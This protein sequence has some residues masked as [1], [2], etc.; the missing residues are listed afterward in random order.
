MRSI[1]S[2]DVD[3][4]HFIEGSARDQQDNQDTGQSSQFNEIPTDDTP[5]SAENDALI[6]LES[7]D[8]GIA[9]FREQ[10]FK[11]NP[12]EMSPEANLFNSTEINDAYAPDYM[13]R[14][15]RQSEILSSWGLPKPPAAPAGQG[16]DHADD[17]S[18]DVDSS[19]ADSEVPGILTPEGSTI[20]DDE[21]D[22]ADRFDSLPSFD[23][24]SSDGQ[25]PFPP[26]PFSHLVPPSGHFTFNS[27]SPLLT[28]I[29]QWPGGAYEEPM[30]RPEST[31]LY[32]DTNEDSDDSDSDIDERFP[33]YEPIF[34]S[35]PQ[36][37][38]VP[39]SKESSVCTSTVSF[40]SHPAETQSDD[41]SSTVPTVSLP[42][43]GPEVPDSQMIDKAP[44]RSL[45]NLDDGESEADDPTEKNGFSD[46]C[47]IYPKE[48]PARLLTASLS[49]L[50]TESE[51]MNSMTSDMIP[52]IEDELAELEAMER[53]RLG[54]DIIEVMEVPWAT[55]MQSSHESISIHSSRSS[56][57]TES[58]H[59]L[60]ASVQQRL[61]YLKR[62]QNLVDRLRV[63][64]SSS[65]DSFHGSEALYASE[66]H[67]AVENWLQGSEDSVQMTRARSSKNKSRT[68]SSS[69]ENWLEQSLDAFQSSSGASHRSKP[70]RLSSSAETIVPG[71]YKVKQT[72][73]IEGH[74]SEAIE[75]SLDEDGS[76]GNKTEESTTLQ[77][78]S[79]QQSE[80]RDSPS[81]LLNKGKKAE[82][83]E[84]VAQ[85]ALLDRIAQI[86][87]ENRPAESAEAEQSENTILNRPSIEIDG[88]EWSRRAARIFAILQLLVD[89]PAPNFAVIATVIV[90]ELSRMTDLELYDALRAIYSVR[91]ASAEPETAE[92]DPASA[93]Y[94]NLVDSAILH[95]QTRRA[96][97]IVDDAINADAVS[98]E[99]SSE[100]IENASVS[101][102][103]PVLDDEVEVDF[104][105]TEVETS[106]STK[107][108]SETELFFRQN[109]TFRRIFT[110]T[111]PSSMLLVLCWISLFDVA[112][113]AWAVV[114]GRIADA[115]H[116][117]S[118]MSA[119][120][121]IEA[122]VLNGI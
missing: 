110:R 19:C 122:A 80:P 112:L 24:Q 78:E 2:V 64:F 101:N 60:V 68:L 111:G 17:S 65:S 31:Y 119:V 7:D 39:S 28:G 120:L 54:S 102:G 6:C 61:Q 77:S 42:P 87:Q 113:F 32:R 34:S 36:R 49:G 73:A 66:S 40:P 98:D 20:C 96:H 55:S 109:F 58:S 10:S 23:S 70:R 93:L 76:S 52:S 92:P 63:R 53:S 11:I 95:L 88:D 8:E 69:A 26:S 47:S 46:T 89:R 90:R 116:Y 97:N 50:P 118:I 114:A 94:S 79:D 99:S 104:T 13:A 71:H 48:G 16:K 41:A 105:K 103:G 9:K 86:S 75:A 30:P 44:I 121:L 37:S 100:D 51:M 3:D 25:E 115:S 84:S 18:V 56:S 67:Q 21:K 81:D 107:P 15:S 5:P 62:L 59:P 43:R 85:R 74:N 108:V 27:A 12:S 57:T 106:K 22:K 1:Q 14:H 4:Y 83:S 72:T 117:G 38:G 29:P 91:A 35:P 33:R 45:N 82:T